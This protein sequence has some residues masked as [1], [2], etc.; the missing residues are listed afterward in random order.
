M[1]IDV[2][3]LTFD[4]QDR[5]WSANLLLMADGEVLTAMP[6]AGKFEEI[7]EVPVLR[8]MVK[9]GDIIG[10]GDVEIR[11]FPLLRT[12]PDTVTD[13]AALIG[14]SPLRSISPER[15]IRLHE[16]AG[17]TLVKKNSLVQMRYSSP[18]MEITATGQA[19]DEGAAGDIIS[20]RNTS[21][22]KLVR[23]VVEDANN[24]SILVPG[25]EPTQTS[26][27]TEAVHAAN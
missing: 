1:T 2:R 21:S 22:R 26:Q 17:P 19:V 13:L 6:V 24:V 14:K 9:S 12:R 16:I 3:G 10:L 15:P 11:D 27:L 23:A 8:R 5:R 7:L 20:V 18:G 25:S 4:A